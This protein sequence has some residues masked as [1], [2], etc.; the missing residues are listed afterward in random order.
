MG[1]SMNSK[2]I[3]LFDKLPTQTKSAFTRQYNKEHFDPTKKAVKK[4]GKK[5]AVA[6][7]DESEEEEGEEEEGVG[8]LLDEDEILE[9]KKG[10]QLEKE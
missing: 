6:T 1:L 7:K 4:G 8:E 2:L 3:E 9:R 10:K 5:G